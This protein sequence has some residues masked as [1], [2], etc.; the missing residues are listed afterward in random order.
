MAANN[1]PSMEELLAKTAKIRTSA[2]VAQRVLRLVEDPAFSVAEVVRV[3]ETD[4]ALATQILCLVNSSYFG[5]PRKVGSLQQAICLL[6]VHTLRLALLNYGVLQ[7][8]GQTLPGPRRD[9]L[10]R[11]SLTVATVAERL[12][13]R[14]EQRGAEEAYCAGLVVDVGMLALA[15]SAR[16]HY[17]PLLINHAP[18]AE[19]IDAER[20]YFGFDHAEFGAR[21]LAQWNL[22]EEFVLAAAK[23]HD[24][25]RGPATT[26]TPIQIAEQVASVLWTKH[27]AEV[28]VAR[29]M[30]TKYYDFTLDD[31]IQL[32]VDCKREL[33]ENA[34]TF[35]VSLR[36]EIDVEGLRTQAMELFVSASVATAVELDGLH[37]L[38]ECSL[39]PL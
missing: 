14:H 26:T 9:E 29:E 20:D 1:A 12:V 2:G 27:G 13:K 22:P 32:A 11:H 10:L 24:V 16:P 35:N 39:P 3:L 34:A 21:L 28:C 38:V 5:L 25:P 23:H 17:E 30:L 37:S 6:G 33:C 19:L 8:L 31:F 7:C 18:G 15:Q 36:D 4:P